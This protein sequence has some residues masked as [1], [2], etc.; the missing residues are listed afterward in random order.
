VREPLGDEARD[1]VFLRCE[2]R[3]RA[4]VAL[5]GRLAGCA[6]LAA[7]A[8]RPRLRAEL[9]EALLRGAQLRTSLDALPQPPQV[10]AVEELR[11]RQVE[12]V[13]DL[14]A[15]AKSLVEVRGG[16]VAVREQRAAVGHASQRPRRTGA[17]GPR[18][19]LRDG[20]LAD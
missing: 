2:L 3:D 6:Q 11:A 13:A 17:R 9:L 14:F 7:G 19:E 20:R 10:L 15:D 18:V 16:G 4:R 5:A 1:V 8:R 12:R